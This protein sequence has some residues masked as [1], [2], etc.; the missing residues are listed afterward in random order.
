MRINRT[1]V[2]KKESPLPP[3]S[4]P[5]PLPTHHLLWNAGEFIIVS[6]C[7]LNFCSGDNAAVIYH[8]SVEGL[9]IP[10]RGVNTCIIQTRVL[11]C[12]IRIT[13]RSVSCFSPFY[14]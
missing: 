13:C 2:K 6:P 8:W 5:S 14:K 10:D 7:P 1:N 12:H 9:L 4:P 3:S 11:I